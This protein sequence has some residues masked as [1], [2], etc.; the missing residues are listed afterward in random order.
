MPFKTLVGLL[1]IALTM[2]LIQSLAPPRTDYKKLTESQWRERLSQEVYEVL[3]EH[4]TEEPFTGI[5]LKEERLGDYRCAGCHTLLFKSEDKYD[6]GTGWPSFTQGIG[7]R[8][9]RENTP[10]AVVVEVSCSNCRSHLGHVFSDG[11]EPTGKRYCIN[12]LALSFEAR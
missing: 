2:I 12:S 1:A 3:R 4:A 10:L 11:P 6:S 8:H 5:L 7:L 9:Q